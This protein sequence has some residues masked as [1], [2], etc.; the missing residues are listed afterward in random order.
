[1]NMFTSN[2]TETTS[3]SLPEVVLSWSLRDVLNKNL[4]K[5]KVKRIPEVFSSTLEY[6]TSFRLPLLEETRASLCSGIESVGQAPACEIIRIEYSKGYKPPK[7]LYYNI[8]TKKIK[9]FKINCGHYDPEAGD[10]V[11]LTNTKPRRT[12]DLIKPDQPL[13]LALVSPTDDESDMTRLLLSKDV[14]SDLC[15]RLGEPVTRVFVTYLTN[16][17]TNM[18]IWKALH[19]DPLVS[20]SL[21]SKI[22]TPIITDTGADCHDSFFDESISIMDSKLREALESFKLDES[23]KSAVL[24]SIAMTKRTRQGG[25]LKFIWGPPGT[26]KTKTVASLLFSLF[27]LKCRTLACAPT[28]IAV[29]QVA[30]R[31]MDLLS[32]SLKYDTYGLGDVVL[33]GNGDRMK[34]DDHHE[35]LNVFLDYRA[36]VLSQCLSP[37]NG[38]KHTLDSMISLLED[39]EEQYLKYLRNNGSLDENS[40]SDDDQSKD[41]N[42]KGDNDSED[43]KPAEGKASKRNS[44][45]HWKDVIG[46]SLKAS[47]GTPG[48][49][50]AQSE[51]LMTFEEFVRKRFYTLGDRMTF[52]MTNLYTHLPTSYIALDV[53]QRMITLLDHLKTLKYAKG[54]TNH[55]YKL[56][57]KR[58]EF[59]EILKSL[60]D[61]FSLPVTVFTGI[62]SIKN[63]CLM[64]ANL[65][66]CTASSSAKMQTEDMKPVEMLIIDEA[67]QLKECESLIPLQIP[68]LSN[69]VFIGDDRQLPAM[70]Q[71][72]VADN[73]DFGRSLF[74]RLSKL[75]QKKHLLKVQYRMH[76]AISLFP[77][78]NFYQKQIIDATCVK[79]LSYK[80]SFLVEEM[81]GP[82]S[83]INVSR[84]K[85]NFERGHSARNL[86][87]AAVVDQIIVKL[88]K[89]HC[90]TKQKV[91]VGVISPYK[92]QVGLIQENTGKR[93]AKC[94]KNEFSV[95]VRSVDGFQGGEED[96]IIISTVRS[97]GNGSIGFLSN[98]QRTNVALTRARHCLWVIGNGTTL[99]NS[100]SVWKDL[101]DD[102]K[103]RGCFYNADEDNDL[104]QAIIHAENDSV[105]AL[106]RQLAAINI[107]HGRAYLR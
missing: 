14:G 16:L 57:M 13:L 40:E 59:L 100:A 61:Q 74:E 79:L 94:D 72:K 41:S 60:P 6:I 32:G 87:E 11:V 104:N 64:N 7:E 58:G 47:S 45:E 12:E 18:R 65:I 106:S 55:A 28:N 1:M 90:S 92:G 2:K 31:L 71:S 54:K 81:Y 84:G 23:Q 29:L 86:V 77:N 97:N 76:P 53:V 24:D 20:I 27:R 5:D 43:D 91:S 49:E 78:N 66:F 96:I 22:L 80:R 46:Q 102:A 99:S 52:L 56:T 10:L 15:P 88:F 21:V 107:R 83:F 101:V 42:V 103:T 3:I 8:L 105:D 67:A 82:Y 62:Q 75:G 95:S 68:G 17:I 9:D 19:P 73:V 85:E 70:V 33:F 69:A 4:Y 36:E 39:P 37:F 34:V 98:H 63:F 51:E 89:R 48:H 38:W 93:Y 30:L 25:R 50:E 26:G 35:L 44:R